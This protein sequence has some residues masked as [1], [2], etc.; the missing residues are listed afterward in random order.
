MIA[1]EHV[2]DRHAVEKVP[3]E[4][5]NHGIFKAAPLVFVDRIV[6]QEYYLGQYFDKISE[7]EDSKL[8]EHF[9]PRLLALDEDRG[10]L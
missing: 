2:C 6:Q 9:V 10:F 7:K 5:I 3:D 1:E 4:Y 8:D